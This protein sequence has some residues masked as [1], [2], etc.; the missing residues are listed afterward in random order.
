MIGIDSLSLIK[1]TE[2]ENGALLLQRVGAP[3]VLALSASVEDQG[4]DVKCCVEISQNG[5]WVPLLR[6]AVV[7]EGL[8]IRMEHWELQV[9]PASS[10]SA[11][12]AHPAA[13]DAFVFGGVPG[14]VAQIQNTIAHMTIQGAK[15]EIM[16]WENFTGFRRWR[17]VHHPQG[18]SEPITLCERTA[19]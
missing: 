10:Y 13:G 12:E 6:P 5:E 15:L 19:P 9:D 18:P 2:A 7:N 17:I 11:F 4:Q 1:T 16:N 8:W 14:I 3:G